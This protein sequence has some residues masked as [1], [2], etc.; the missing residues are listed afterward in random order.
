MKG[1]ITTR[2]P[3]DKEFEEVKK[4]VEEFWLDNRN[5]LKEQ[6]R[7][8]LYKGK[9]AAFGRIRRHMDAIEFCSLG[10]VKELR[11]KG[12][13]RAM[14]QCLLAGIK[15]DS[16]LVTVIPDFFSKLGFK[17]VEQYPDSI[18]AKA[19]LCSTQYHVGEEYKVMK[20]KVL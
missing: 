4:L 8:L 17:E 3:D 14:M 16:Y 5:M 12:F 9:L 7:I 10:V 13:G 11:G 18:K 19:N 20:Y 2:Q 1:E 6:F 15:G